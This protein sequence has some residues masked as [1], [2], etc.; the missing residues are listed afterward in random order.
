MAK[1]STSLLGYLFVIGCAITAV[2]FVL[3]IF[4]ANILGIAKAS[5][6]GFDLVGKGDSLMKVAAL[7]VFIGAVAGIVFEFVPVGGVSN[8][9]KLIA[10][11][12]SIAGGLYCFF[13]T[14][15]VG[16]K[17]AAKVLSVGFYAIIAGWI[18][19]LVGWLLGKK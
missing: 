17:L 10:L 7:L 13:N 18:V 2:G 1:K 9:L 11:V 3:P 14:S 12:I 4:S 16:L 5:V 6:N 8:L 19:A 15:D